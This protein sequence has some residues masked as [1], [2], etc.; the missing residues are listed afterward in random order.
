MASDVR[1]YVRACGVCQRTKGETQA[2]RGLL[3]SLPALDGKWSH[4]TMYLVTCLPTTP[5]G[6]NT[7]VV[8][9]DRL[10]KMRQG[11]GT[12]E[13]SQQLL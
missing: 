2:T 3:H 12:D 11:H 1:E 10:T 8:F 7:V 6:H 5:E 9:T 4:S 13:M